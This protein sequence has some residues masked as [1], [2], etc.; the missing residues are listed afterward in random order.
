ML[1]ILLPL[2][3]LALATPLAVSAPAPALL[4]R[5][6]TT[7]EQYGGKVLTVNNYTV[8]PNVFIQDS[9]TFNATGYNTL[10][11]SFGLIDK[12][13]QRWKNFTE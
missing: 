12:S 10:N 1:P 6:A 2:L 4:P 7:D 9:P 8:V 3:P 11:D 5:W 13:A